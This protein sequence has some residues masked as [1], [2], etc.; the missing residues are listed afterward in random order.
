MAMLKKWTIN[1]VDDLRGH[2]I[3]ISGITF[4][5]HR[6]K[7]GLEIST[8]KVK[9]F[10][11]NIEGKSILAR[12]KNTLYELEM[13]E[14]NPDNP[15][16]LKTLAEKKPPE[17]SEDSFE[18]YRWYTEV[19]TYLNIEMNVSIPMFLRTRFEHLNKHD[20]NTIRDWIKGHVEYQN[21]LRQILLSG[22]EEH[23]DFLLCFSDSAHYYYNFLAIKNEKGGI[24][25]RKEYSIHVGTFQDSIMIQPIYT[26][27]SESSLRYF[28]YKGNKLHFYRIRKH[29]S[30]GG[31]LPIRFSIFNSGG[32]DLKIGTH[33]GA[34]VICPGQIRV[35]CETDRDALNEDVSGSDMY[36]A[37][38]LEEDNESKIRQ[39]KYI[40]NQHVNFEYNQH[41]YTGIIVHVDSQ[42]TYFQKEEPSYDI[43]D[44]STGILRKHIRESSI[45]E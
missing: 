14:M 21:E 18:V 36:P 40:L 26:D 15:R 32:D 2:F 44:E 12:T 1:T 34:Y 37:I 13:S 42:G 30:N 28:P 7:D 43:I 27:Q 4:D 17:I 39:P 38:L 5:H 19:I 31:N 8:T 45:L 33:W 24:E 22:F 25:I 3:Y 23:I 41:N 10:E 29:D 16:V 9:S 20:I 6:I 11:I 35:I